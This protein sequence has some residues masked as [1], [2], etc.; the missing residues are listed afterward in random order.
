MRPDM[1]V[2]ALSVP[3][4]PALDDGLIQSG[5]GF[6]N[7]KREQV[8]TTPAFIPGPSGTRTSSR[9][10]QGGVRKEH[11]N[12]AEVQRDRCPDDVE[13]EGPRYTFISNGNIRI[14]GKGGGNLRET[15]GKK[16][17]KR[18]PL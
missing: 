15:T 10:G 16:Y 6:V 2:P 11:D 1:S 9:V 14:I 13:G 5:P 18:W 3:L 4:I 7:Q 17:K 12:E 8:C